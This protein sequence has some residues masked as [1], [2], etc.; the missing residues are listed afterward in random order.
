MSL[1]RRHMHCPEMNLA[2]ARTHPVKICDVCAKTEALMS[3]S[4]TSWDQARIAMYNEYEEN[5]RLPVGTGLGVFRFGAD[6][7]LHQP[8]VAASLWMYVDPD[9]TVPRGTSPF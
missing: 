6:V 1:I 4:P 9:S 8:A 2:M 7:N 3:I 5:I